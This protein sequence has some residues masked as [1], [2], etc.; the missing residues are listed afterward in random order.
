LLS[1][2]E[3]KLYLFDNSFENYLE[4]YETIIDMYGV[5]RGDKFFREMYMIG[6]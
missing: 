2:N 3:L 4:E 1:N 6:E 5:R